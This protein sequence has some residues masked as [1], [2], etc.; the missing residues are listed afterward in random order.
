MMLRH[1]L[2][3]VRAHDPSANWPLAA[4]CLDAMP[5]DEPATDDDAE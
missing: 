1:A 2:A 5:A 4:D 3:Q